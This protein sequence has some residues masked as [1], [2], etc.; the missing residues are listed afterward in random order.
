MEIHLTPEQE[1]KLA[2]IAQHQ[3]VSVDAFLTDVVLGLLDEKE[4]FRRA[5]RIGL[6][7]ADAGDFIEQE[8][9]DARFEKM[10]RAG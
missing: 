5:V 9:M 4:D 8:E 10:M 2:E 6:A 3:G 1:A 7:Q